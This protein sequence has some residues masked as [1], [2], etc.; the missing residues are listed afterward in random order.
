MVVYFVPKF[1]LAVWYI[2]PALLVSNT[3][4]TSASH[5]DLWQI[6]GYT[7]W[8]VLGYGLVTIPCHLPV[9]QEYFWAFNNVEHTPRSIKDRTP[10]TVSMDPKGATHHENIYR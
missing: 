8:A 4:G 7:T 10:S 5:Q 6:A 1:N 2:L 3:C 9:M